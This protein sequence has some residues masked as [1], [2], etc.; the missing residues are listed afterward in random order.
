MWL[1]V[2]LAELVFKASIK[3]FKTIENR[4]LRIESLERVDNERKQVKV[5]ERRRENKWFLIKIAQIT[6][7]KLVKV[8][9][10]FGQALSLFE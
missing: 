10:V 7:S 8:W 4:Y 3:G 1:V 9:F 2:S 5:S 6:N